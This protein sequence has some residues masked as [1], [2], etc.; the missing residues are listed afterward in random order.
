MADDALLLQYYKLLVSCAGPYLVAIIVQSQRIGSGQTRCVF[1]SY[2]G[3][4]DGQGRRRCLSVV[5]E[6]FGQEHKV[7]IIPLLVLP[8]VMNSSNFLEVGAR[9]VGTAKHEGSNALWQKAFKQTSLVCKSNI[10][11]GGCGYIVLV[12]CLDNW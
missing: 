8:L 5:S 9:G 7:E 10:S 6:P 2:A 11:G 3:N 12:Y 4:V 1:V